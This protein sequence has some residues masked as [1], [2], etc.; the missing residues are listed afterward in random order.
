MKIETFEQT[1]ISGVN[2]KEENCEEAIQLIEKLGLIG[3]HEMVT[4]VDGQDM[5]CPYREMNIKELKVYECLFPVKTEIKN[6]KQGM[7][8]LRVLQ[9][10]AHADSLGYFNGLYVWSERSRP[11]D[12]LL[13]GLKKQQ[14][15]WGGTDHVFFILARWGEALESF[16]VL[17][18][19]AKNELIEDFKSKAI[20]GKAKCNAALNSLES[21]ALSHLSGEFVSIPF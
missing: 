7:I 11:R 5:R 20:S 12:P 16:E 10:A 8:P 6:Y 14:N 19:R 15:S 4:K 18:E 13:V 17:Y 9:V 21:L 2:P 3:Q 1:E